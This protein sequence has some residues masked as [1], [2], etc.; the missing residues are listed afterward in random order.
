MGP[1]ITG[2]PGRMGPGWLGCAGTIGPGGAGFG[3]IGPGIG[4]VGCAGAGLGEPG[5]AGGVAGWPGLGIC[6][7]AFKAMIR[8]MTVRKNSA[9]IFFCFI[10]FP[11]T[12]LT[13]LEKPGANPPPPV[14]PVLSYGNQH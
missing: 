14:S 12:I 8:P 7:G 5:W 10:N 3:M 2:L 13:L 4:G 11:M 1:G 6:A 9:C